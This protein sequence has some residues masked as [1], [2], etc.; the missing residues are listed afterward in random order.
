MKT[1]IGVMLLQAKKCHRLTGAP[2]A[3]RETRSRPSLTASEGINPSNTLNTS[4]TV[5]HSFP[6]CP[7][8]VWYVVM[9]TP[10]SSN[11]VQVE[12]PSGD[13]E[14]DLRLRSRAVAT[15]ALRCSQ[16]S[17]TKASSSIW[18][19]GKECRDLTGREL[20]LLDGPIQSYGSGIPV[21]FR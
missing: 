21:P 8:C 7:P 17:P 5:Q 9:A 15:S 4:G 3:G 20:M 1:E 14:I 19:S 10:G 13:P 12:L 2:E 18:A 11:R 6:W 16:S